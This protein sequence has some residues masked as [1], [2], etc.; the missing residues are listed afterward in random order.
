MRNK[1][2]IKL[3]SNSFRCTMHLVF[4][5]LGS[6]LLAV[7]AP[8]LMPDA[9]NPWLFILFPLVHLLSARG[10]REG[11]YYGYFDFLDDRHLVEGKGNRCIP[12]SVGTK[13]ST[14]VLNRFGT[15]KTSIRLEPPLKRKSRPAFLNASTRPS[16]KTALWASSGS[17]LNSFWILRMFSGV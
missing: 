6:V 1:K 10:A 5:L 11:H 3:Q 14:S 17:T 4:L 9:S 2:K 13:I 8:A 12:Q 15:S 7:Y 16:A